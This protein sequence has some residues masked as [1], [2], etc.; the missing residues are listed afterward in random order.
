MGHSDGEA[1]QNTPWGPA[2]ADLVGK[3]S[4]RRFLTVVVFAIVV[5]D[6][7]LGKVVEAGAGPALSDNTQFSLSVLAELA[8][9]CAATTCQDT[10]SM[11]REIQR[12]LFPVPSFLSE[13]A[14]LAAAGGSHCCRRRNYR[15]GQSLDLANDA[16]HTLD[17]LGSRDPGPPNPGAASR[18]AAERVRQARVDMGAPPSDCPMGEGAFCALLSK[19]SVHTSDR[20]DIRSYAKE[21]VSWPVAGSRPVRFVDAI[22]AGNRLGLTDRERHLLRSDD[23]AADARTALG[24]ERPH[25][26]P[27]LTRSPRI[28][29][30]FVHELHRRGMVGFRRARNGAR[31]ALGIFFVVMKD[32]TIRLTGPVAGGGPQTSD[33]LAVGPVLSV[34]RSRRPR[35]KPCQCVCGAPFTQHVAQIWRPLKART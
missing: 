31:P 29:G 33:V 9:G 23:A 7:C 22:G 24:V 34:Q 12:D 3:D 21:L 30:D 1:D 15:P 35:A 25:S 8:C 14:S 13:A 16:I 10:D 4:A 5:G 6:L 28:Y 18:L 27:C 2:M 19:S 26:D 32:G 20:T 17:V 11:G